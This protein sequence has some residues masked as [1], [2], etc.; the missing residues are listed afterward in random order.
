MRKILD[1]TYLYLM[2]I[3][4]GLLGITFHILNVVQLALLF[5]II[6]FTSACIGIVRERAC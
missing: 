1:P 3:G 2:S 5:D 4:T 6:C